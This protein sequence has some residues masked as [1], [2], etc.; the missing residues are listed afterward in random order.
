MRSACSSG[1]NSR[2]VRAVSR[3]KDPIERS[4]HSQWLDSVLS[5]PERCLLIAETA[6]APVGAVRFDGLADV[7]EVS[8]TVAP[9][10]RGR[11]LGTRVI[12]E[13]TEL[14]LAA[15]PELRAVRAQ[16]RGDN[17]RSVRAFAA[18][19][20]EPVGEADGHLVLQAVR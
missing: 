12:R 14:Q 7:A 2:E 8:V 16:I 6:A 11:G 3:T 18:A 15:R 10:A 17:E 5:D 13:S 9:D 1:G 19:G 20:D 4:S